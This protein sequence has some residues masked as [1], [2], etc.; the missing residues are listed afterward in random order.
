MTLFMC[1][2]RQWLCVICVLGIHGASNFSGNL[3]DLLPRNDLF[4]PGLFFV[5]CDNYLL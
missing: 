4:G 1:I 3:P 2:I 5:D